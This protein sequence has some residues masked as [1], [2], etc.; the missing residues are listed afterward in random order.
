MK[1]IWMG[2][3]HR[4]E[5]PPARQHAR[6]LHVPIADG[7]AGFGRRRHFVDPHGHDAP[8]PA[9]GERA[10]AAR[11]I[12]TER[13]EE[14]GALEVAGPRLVL[15][16]VLEIAVVVLIGLRMNDDGVRQAGGLDEFEVFL[17][18]VCGG[19]VRSVG[20]IGD[21]GRVEEVDVRLDVD[22]GWHCGEQSGGRSHGA[23]ERLAPGED[24]GVP[25]CT[26]L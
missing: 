6:I 21:A 25:H 7:A 11:R 1:C 12:L 16:A 18:G 24:V 14:A 26:T 10:K 17:Q 22:R 20:R 15:E 4:G 13:I 5:G 9:P 8:G 3:P 2:Q 19:L 23:Q